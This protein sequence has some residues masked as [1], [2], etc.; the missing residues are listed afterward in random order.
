M[1]KYF[2]YIILKYNLCLYNYYSHN[3][4]RNN[5]IQIENKYMFITLTIE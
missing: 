4:I 2:N 1:S 5:T 3:F